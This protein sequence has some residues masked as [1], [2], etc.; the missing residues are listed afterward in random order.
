M[1]PCPSIMSSHLLIL[2][3]PKNVRT[4]QESW[5]SGI[6][7]LAHGGPWWPSL[8]LGPTYSLRCFS[9]YSQTFSFTFSSARCEVGQQMPYLTLTSGWIKIGQTMMGQL[10]C[11]LCALCGLF[12]LNIPSYIIVSRCFI[13]TWLFYSEQFCSD[14]QE[15]VVEKWDRYKVSFTTIFSSDHCDCD[16]K[17][18]AKQ[19]RRKK[20]ADILFNLAMSG[21]MSGVT[22]T[23]AIIVTLNQP[24]NL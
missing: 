7:C 17:R 6:L 9:K 22:N 24:I 20:K 5:F 11:G 4:R 13:L 14:L 2:V 23:I 21:G 1:F 16:R 15:Q 8:Q 12:L 10:F 19:G 18:V 3:L